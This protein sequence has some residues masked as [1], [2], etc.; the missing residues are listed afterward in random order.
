MPTPQR[1]GRPGRPARPSSASAR[2]AP[3]P[4]P[5]DEVLEGEE[6]FLDE[7]PV[8]PEGPS[9][10]MMVGLGAALLFAVLLAMLVFSKR[11][12]LLEVE[13]ISDEPLQDVVVKVN[14][15]DYR[16]GDMRPNEIGGERPARTPGNDVE[17]HYRV[18]N[19]GEFVKRVNKKDTKGDDAIPDFLKFTGTFRLR[20]QADGVHQTVV[21]E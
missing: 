17:V 21:T 4:L 5:D 10:V 1:P 9:V 12:F 2:R 18:P 3:P 16:I 11:G 19:R 6:E 14:G 7:E 13:N 8:K 20:I 15:T